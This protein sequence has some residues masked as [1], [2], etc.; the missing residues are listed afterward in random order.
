M[1][2]NAEATMKAFASSSCREIMIIAQQN[3]N[4]IQWSNGGKKCKKQQLRQ[5]VG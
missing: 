3:E 2:A 5:L 1:K 4:E